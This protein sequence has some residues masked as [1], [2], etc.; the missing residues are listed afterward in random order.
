MLL[1]QNHQRKK[2]E[3]CFWLTHIYALQSKI[4]LIKLFNSFT[5][6]NF[7]RAECILNVLLGFLK[8]NK[9]IYI[10][11]EDRLYL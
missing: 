11:T 8:L 10:I 1:I 6:Y 4:C 3:S 5:P 9:I 7:G 2:D